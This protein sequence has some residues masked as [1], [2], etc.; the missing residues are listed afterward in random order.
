MEAKIA[1]MFA[2]P[3]THGQGVNV[4]GVVR[5]DG[6][7]KKAQL[8]MDVMGLLGDL[9]IINVRLNQDQVCMSFLMGFF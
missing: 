5:M 4:T 1:G 6:V 9:S 2:I 3:N 8:A 7:A